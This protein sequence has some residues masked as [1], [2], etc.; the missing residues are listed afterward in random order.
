MHQITLNSNLNFDRSV[1]TPFQQIIWQLLSG[2]I[3]TGFF[4]NLKNN[5]LQIMLKDIENS[6]FGKFEA[7]FGK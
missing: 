5:K 1:R 4:F 7:G 6:L 3:R 2:K